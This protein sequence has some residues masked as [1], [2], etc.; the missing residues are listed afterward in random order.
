M[1]AHRKLHRR[2]DALAML[3]IRRRFCASCKGALKSLRLRTTPDFT[4]LRPII[5]VERVL[6]RWGIFQS[7]SKGD[8]I[9]RASFVCGMPLNSIPGCIHMQKE[10]SVCPQCGSTAWVASGLCLNCLLSLGIGAR[11]QSSETLDA[12]L[13]Q[14]DIDETEFL[15]CNS[16]TANH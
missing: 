12:L 1:A 5:S 8:S 3:H 14:M 4:Q 7:W 11:G 9:N 6:E 2:G 16:A 13:T 10:P 15:A